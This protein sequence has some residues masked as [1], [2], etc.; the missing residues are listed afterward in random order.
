MVFASLS[1]N[2]IT[3]AKHTISDYTRKYAYESRKQFTK[4]IEEYSIKT[5]Q[6]LIDESIDVFSLNSIPPKNQLIKWSN[7]LLLR[8]KIAFGFHF[9]ECKLG[10][11]TYESIQHMITLHRT[12]EIKLAVEQ[13]IIWLNSSK[14]LPKSINTYPPEYLTDKFKDVLFG[15][16]A[17]REISDYGMTLNTLAELCC[18]RW[19][20]SDHML[21]ICNILNSFQNDSLVIYFNFVGNIEHFISCITTVPEK[22]IFIVNIGKN[23]EKTFTGTSINP[24][25][26]WSFAAY[27]NTE[28]N[29]YYGDSLGWIA[30]EDFLLK[31][32]L[33][34]KKLYHNNKTFNMIYCHDPITH[35]YGGK[36]CS[37]LCKRNYPLQT[38][39]DICGLI[40]VVLC[41]IAC[42]RYDYFKH[43]ICN[44]DQLNN[45][46]IFLKEPTKYSKYL[47]L[48]LMAWFICKEVVIEYVV[49]K[50]ISL[51]LSDSDYDEN[52]ICTNLAESK[53]E[54]KS[55]GS[56]KEKNINSFEC[57]FCKSF[58]TKK[59]NL[60]R[61]IKNIHKSS[62]D[63][64]ASIRT[65]N[66][67][68]L[69][70]RFQ[71]QRITDL[72]KHLSLS[73]CFTFQKELLSFS[74][75]IDFEKWKSNI[76]LS[77]LSQYIVTSGGKVCKDGKIITYYQCN[78]SGLYN[79]LSSGKRR[80]QSSG[81]RKIDKNCASTLKVTCSD[82]QVVVNA[83]YSHYGH[84][85][86]IQHLSL[87]KCQK[88]E[89]AA[90]LQMGITKDY[91]LDEIRDELVGCSSR[92]CIIQKKD[93]VNR[94]KAFNINS[95]Q[96]H[97]ND[98]DSVAAWLKEWQ[99]KE[100]NPI[101][102]YKLQG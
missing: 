62:E 9:V 55:S 18:S 34:I 97:P 48:V 73:H 35:K 74:N 33:L 28:C 60:Q 59:C 82:T 11:F 58:F 69:E 24:G 91:I 1:Q 75:L 86:E 17:N 63:A 14:L 67:F 57:C 72:R 84:Q 26:H 36:L 47:R 56:N 32:D 5:N 61:H 46:Y 44:D 27:N 12:Q 94:E 39:G 15:K 16:P 21:L 42:L 25:C 19:L 80:I 83:C 8:K 41:A 78:R 99:M 40:T 87:T 88:R 52:F 79:C 6:F 90:K 31:V 64:Q 29:F 71:S 101:L 7:E 20:S 89:I 70:C 3:L 37:S 53:C 54:K 10:I 4:V 38:C 45:N 2:K 68:C 51:C 23:N 76:E 65:G 22:L 66:S 95:V 92:L 100:N 85:T 93:F 43:I 49:P 30:P 81:T 77:C 13:E 102:H 96:R 98:Q 50:S